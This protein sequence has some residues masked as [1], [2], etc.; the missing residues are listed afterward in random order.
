[1]HTSTTIYELKYKYLNADSFTASTTL[2]DKVFHIDGLRPKAWHFIN[3][4]R[5][6]RRHF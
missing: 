6:T 5:T 3:H 2:E 1:M 4:V